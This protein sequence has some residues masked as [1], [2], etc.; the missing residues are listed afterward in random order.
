MDEPT[1][2]AGDVNDPNDNHISVH[3][4]GTQTNSAEES[5]SIG[6]STAIPNLS[7][8]NLHTVKIDYSPGAMDIYVDDLTQP[9]VS[10]PITLTTTLSL[11]SGGRAWVGFTG[12]TGGAVERHDI[13]S[14]S[15]T[16]GSP[17]GSGRPRT[18]IITEPN[19][20]GAVR[21]PQD[22]HMECNPFFSST[23]RNHLCTDWEIWT[24]SPSERIWFVSCITGIERLH[25]HQGDG[26]FIG[27]HAG[28]TS[29]IAST[30]YVLKCRH[31]DDSGVAA[32]EWSLYG[33]RNFR[34]GARQ[35][36]SLEH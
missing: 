34:T 9:K 24:A 1:C 6:W 10:A 5:A 25:I 17:P 11:A 15:L 33:Q 28:R 20:D 30:D 14:W 22:V 12:S 4:R 19:I 23:G 36:H 35:Q 27:S 8:G 21:S 3:T 7:D 26:T 2:D 29:F 16:E 13:T 31:R 32:T 18:P